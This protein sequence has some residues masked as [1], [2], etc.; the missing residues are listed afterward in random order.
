MCGKDLQF[1][2]FIKE[3][4]FMSNLLPII[5]FVMGLSGLLGVA[6]GMDRQEVVL[7][8]NVCMSVIPIFLSHDYMKVLSPCDTLKK[9]A[10]VFC[11]YAPHLGITVK[12]KERTDH[13]LFT[14][15]FLCKRGQEVCTKNVPYQLDMAIELLS[16]EDSMF[17]PSDFSHMYRELEGLP[18]RV[19]T[20]CCCCV[21]VLG[22]VL[23]L[24]FCL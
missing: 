13:T 18:L 17:R 9:R 21:G 12:K 23:M 11:A 3:G 2:L 4:C 20:I 14:P 8:E 16:I 6:Y 19:N 10:V 7:K 1:M 24:T 22:M 15:I 5:I